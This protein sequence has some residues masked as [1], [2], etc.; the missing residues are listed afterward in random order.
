VILPLIRRHTMPNQ[1]SLRTRN[2]VA[3]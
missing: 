3:L 1:R 2:C